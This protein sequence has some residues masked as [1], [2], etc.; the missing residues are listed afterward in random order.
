MTLWLRRLSLALKV[1]E[2][3]WMSR[4]HLW[5]LFTISFIPAFSKAIFFLVEPRP[6][7]YGNILLWWSPVAHQINANDTDNDT[8]NVGGPPR[9]LNGFAEIRQLFLPKA[10]CIRSL[11]STHWHILCSGCRWRRQRKMTLSCFS[12]NFR[13]W[14]VQTRKIML[15]FVF[16]R[17]SFRKSQF[18]DRRG[19]PTDLYFNSGQGKWTESGHPLHM[20][21]CLQL[22][23]SQCG[24]KVRLWFQTEWGSLIFF[25]ITL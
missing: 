10:H 7:R 12:F 6:Y 24:P 20:F 9:S 14:Q 16:P 19:L 23:A 2:N 5:C 11:A 25:P 21:L 1:C 17:Q 15:Y 4:D 8:D 18:L 3:S 22:N 13:F